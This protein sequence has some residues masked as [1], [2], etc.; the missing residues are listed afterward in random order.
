MRVAIFSTK[1]V[2]AG[3]RATPPEGQPSPGE[4]PGAPTENSTPAINRSAP[5]HDTTSEG[6]LWAA[7]AGRLPADG[8][9]VLSNR[10]KGNP[11]SQSE[12]GYDVTDTRW[13]VILYRHLEGYVG[14]GSART[15]HSR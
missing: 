8:A 13:R 4:R 5:A 7:Y 1:D 6:H 9:R 11:L 2:V 3:W 15:E 12:R 14:R 10:E